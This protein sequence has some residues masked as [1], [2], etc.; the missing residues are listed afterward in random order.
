MK[1]K[2]RKWLGRERS[3][4]REKIELVRQGYVKKL[5]NHKNRNGE[6]K[7]RIIHATL[8]RSYGKEQN[9][10]KNELQRSYK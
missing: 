8:R 9:N 6:Q 4:I 7:E 10:V 3:D 2:V 1:R 5:K